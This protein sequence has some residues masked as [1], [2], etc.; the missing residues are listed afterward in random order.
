MTDQTVESANNSI[1]DEPRLVHGL[2]AFWN[3]PFTVFPAMILLLIMPLSIIF[4]P[5]WIVPPAEIYVV[6][7]FIAIIRITRG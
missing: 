4:H 3:S 6:G 5:A 2:S 1:A 7:M